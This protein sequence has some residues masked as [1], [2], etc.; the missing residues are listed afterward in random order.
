MESGDNRMY[1][2]AWGQDQRIWVSDQT[3]AGGPGWSNWY[4]LATAVFSAAPTAVVN[5]QGKVEVY[6]VGTDRVVYRNVQT[7]SG[8]GG[9]SGWSVA[10]GCCIQGKV[11]V[12]RDR[13][14]RLNV[15]GLGIDNALYVA[16][17]VEAG[18]SYRTAFY[19]WVFGV[20]GD[21]NVYTQA[22]NDTDPNTRIFGGWTGVPGGPVTGDLTGV[23]NHEG[24]YDVVPVGVFVRR[25]DN[26]V[27]YFNPWNG[28]WQ[29]IGEGTLTSDPIAIAGRFSGDC[30]VMSLGS[31][32]RAYTTGRPASTTCARRRPGPAGPRWVRTGCSPRPPGRCPPTGSVRRS[33]RIP[34]AECS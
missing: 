26:K 14:N 2:F 8:P 27:Y 23:V 3:T 28:Q 33:A 34:A 18:F 6:A 5:P 13:Y 30:A 19:H 20:G 32:G 1:L 25:A 16:R 11:S 15:F 21:G 22:V 17:Q 7:G 10:G 31:D 24:G 9:W 29:S 4:P 12:S